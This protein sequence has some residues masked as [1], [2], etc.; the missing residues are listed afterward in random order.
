M[1][2]EVLGR[3]ATQEGLDAML[4][5]GDLEAINKIRRGHN[6]RTRGKERDN[7]SFATKFC[8]FSNPKCYPLYDDNVRLALIEL[9]KKR[10]PRIHF[11]TPGLKEPD[12]LKEAVD[13]IIEVFDLKDY[14]T[15]DRALWKYEDRA[16][17]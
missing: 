6:I 17:S 3:L 14:Q 10:S 4:H 2:V 16:R 12:R 5:R 11:E 13:Q 1:R 15:V 8:H 7:Y 9:R